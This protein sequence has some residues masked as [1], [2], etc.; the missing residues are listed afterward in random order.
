M[1][2]KVT[3]GARLPIETEPERLFTFE[4]IAALASASV[5]QVRRWVTEGK[6]GFVTMPQGR[7]VTLKQWQ[8]FV[9]DNSIEP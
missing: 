1:A 3:R 2:T 4:D 6:L 5:R 8:R 7:R 9:R